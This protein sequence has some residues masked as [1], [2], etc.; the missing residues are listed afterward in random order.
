MKVR[1]FAFSKRSDRLDRWVLKLSLGVTLGLVAR[2]LFLDPA[3]AHHPKNHHLASL[4]SFDAEVYCVRREEV[5]GFTWDDAFA[6]VVNTLQYDDQTSDWHLLLN[7]PNPKNTQVLFSPVGDCEYFA[8]EALT[9]VEIIYDV[10]N[11]GG[12]GEVSC[13]TPVDD[14]V[15]LLC[16][17]C[18][19]E[20][21]E[22]E[23]SVPLVS[24]YD[25]DS[26]DALRFKFEVEEQFRI[27]V[28]KLEIPKEASLIDIASA[29][30]SIVPVGSQG[31]IDRSRASREQRD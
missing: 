11:D 17:A 1:E 14:L 13:V 12:C 5:D 22:V 6:A 25:F 28:S 31:Y 8:G 29:L 3:S 10:R 2:F 20:K 16:E 27:D 30:N 9:K 19:Y 18:G 15:L 23:R 24:P 7:G 4:N 21:R 26:L